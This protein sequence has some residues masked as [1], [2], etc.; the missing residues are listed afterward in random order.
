MFQILNNKLKTLFETLKW[1]WQPF[2]D[3]K[4]YH[5]LENIGYPYL[6]FENI[7]FTAEILD[8]CDNLR[9]F[10]FEVLVFQEITETG[11]R[12]EAKEIIYKSMDD[13]LDLL[14]KNY[15]LWLTE[16]KMVNPTWWTIEP[17]VMQNGKCLVWRLQVE[18]QTYNSLI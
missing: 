18:I 4:D 10:T 9:T 16:V 5:T 1:S 6:T 3:V 12:Q 8:N 14:D 2:V 7:D 17:L 15:T 11:G 13:L